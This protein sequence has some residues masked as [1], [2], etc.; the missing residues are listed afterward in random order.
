M[1]LGQR[2][3]KNLSFERFFLFAHFATALLERPYR[4]LSMD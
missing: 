3:S 2:M 4:L 1:L